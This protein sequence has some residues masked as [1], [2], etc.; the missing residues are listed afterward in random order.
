[1]QKEY[2]RVEVGSNVGEVSSATQSPQTK[3][4]QSLMRWQKLE[5]SQGCFR[6]RRVR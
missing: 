1:M 3:S 5:G 6:A 2:E 4:V